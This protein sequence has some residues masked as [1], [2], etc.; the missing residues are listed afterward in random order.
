MVVT[1]LAPYFQ[2]CDPMSSADYARFEARV[3]V[4][5]GLGAGVVMAICVDSKII[6]SSLTNITP[7]E[8][9][10]LF[11]SI[12]A[13]FIERLVPNLLS[14]GATTV[15]MPDGK[16]EEKSTPAAESPPTEDVGAEATDPAAEPSS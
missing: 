4:L 10:T 6:A 8:A 16:G 13:G 9:G 7:P 15:A 1:D 11:F 2:H 3:R 5:T 14:S 12:V